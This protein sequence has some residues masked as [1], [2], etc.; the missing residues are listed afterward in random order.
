MMMVREKLAM[1][2]KQ[3]RAKLLASQKKDNRLNTGLTHIT[4][5]TK[6]AD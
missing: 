5:R 6:Y 3:Q 1:K 4:N 2:A